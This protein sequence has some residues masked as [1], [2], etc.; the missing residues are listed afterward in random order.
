MP[1]VTLEIG[2]RN[3]PV[4]CQP[5]EEEQ[6]QKAAALLAAEAETLQAHNGRVPEARMLLLAGLMLADKLLEADTAVSGAEERIRQLQAQV[7]SVEEK[8]ARMAT[9]A[10]HSSE[11][12][13]DEALTVAQRE[14][15][16]AKDMLE[17]VAT[18]LE[19]L[20]DA[21]EGQG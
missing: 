11:D 15:E 8:A 20:A 16:A 3:F 9:S 13:D 14:S 17:Q 12:K 7:R 5:G 6:L 1:E 2:G 18:H 19:S 4:V 21:L 10:L